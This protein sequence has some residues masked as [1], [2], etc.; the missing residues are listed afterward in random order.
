MADRRTPLD[1]LCALDASFLRHADP[2]QSA[3]PEANYDEFLLQFKR[4][5]FTR[6]EHQLPRRLAFQYPQ[7]APLSSYTALFELNEGSSGLIILS[8]M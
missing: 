1:N 8:A 3:G 5:H 2:P 4:P 7:I 6:S